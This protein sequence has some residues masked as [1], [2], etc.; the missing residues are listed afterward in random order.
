LSAQDASGSSGIARV[1]LFQVGRGVAPTPQFR[2]Y[3]E[4]C[5]RKQPGRRSSALTKLV[6]IPPNRE[7]NLA[8]EVVGAR[9]IANEAQDEAIDARLVAREQGLHGE[10]IAGCD[11]RDQRRVC[12]VASRARRRREAGT[13]G[14]LVNSG[15]FATIHVDLP[16]CR[17]AKLL[18]LGW[19]PAGLAQCSAFLAWHKHRRIGA[20]QS[21][22]PGSC[23]IRL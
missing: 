20:P 9:G 13:G 2:E 3:L 17:I 6:R 15:N 22:A 10:P 19:Q 11:P 16:S 12:H 18:T 5:N 8:G 23:G 1:R 7:K 14:S 21:I 4:A